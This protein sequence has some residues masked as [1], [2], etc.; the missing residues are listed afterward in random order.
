MKTIT[1]NFNV[2]SYDEL[3]E[4]AKEKVKE[5]YLSCQEPYIFTDSCKYDLETLFPESTL[6]VQYSLSSCQGDGFNIYGKLNLNDVFN[7]LENGTAPNIVEDFKPFTEKE[8]RTLRFYNNYCD[9]IL[10]ENDTRYSYCVIDYI[11]LFIDWEHELEYQCIRNIN[12]ETIQKLENAIIRIF[13]NL[14]EQYE[15]DGYSFFYEISD[16]DMIETCEANG[17]T[18]LEDGTIFH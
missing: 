3:D 11:D 8:K 18:F 1:K 16:K 13:S 7:I 14:C 6:D 12:K 15:K 5:W 9:I 10:P 4:T 17:Y 2:Y